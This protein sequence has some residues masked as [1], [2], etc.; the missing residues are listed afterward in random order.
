M[1]EKFKVTTDVYASQGQRLANAFIDFFAYLLFAF[2]VGILL[3]LSTYLFESETIIK[4]LNSDQDGVLDYVMS[5]GIYVLYYIIFEIT[6]Q[7]TIGKY[8]SK[9]KVV[10]VF[11]NKPKLSAI[12]GRTFARF[13]PFEAFSFLG[14]NA[15][16]W[17]DSLPDLYVIDE[18]KWNNKKNM[19]HDF[20]ELGKN[21]ND[22]EQ[23]IV[24]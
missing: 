5:Y 17:H 20:K 7:K 14:S 12:I 23:K 22:I 13:I 15:R 19:F 4:Y 1:Q 8:I 21:A 16:G 24:F 18:E 2:I 9:T 6:T 11:G 3:G 10:D